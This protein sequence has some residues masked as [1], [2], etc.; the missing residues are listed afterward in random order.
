M[1]LIE[2]SK[3]SN[4]EFITNKLP[5]KKNISNNILENYTKLAKM[6]SS[7]H[8][9]EKYETNKNLMRLNNKFFLNF[10]QIRLTLEN[11][12]NCNSDISSS[13]S[14]EES[15]EKLIDD[16]SLED[17]EFA[18]EKK[19][20]ETP[21]IVF[22]SLAK[23]VL[24][25]SERIESKKFSSHLNLLGGKIL[26]TFPSIHLKTCKKIFE[27]FFSYRKPIEKNNELLVNQKA[28]SKIFNI[29]KPD[30]SLKEMCFIDDYEQEKR[31]STE[32]VTD[33]GKKSL[34]KDFG[35]FSFESQ[36]NE[37]SLE[38]ES[39]SSLKYIEN[40]L[41]QEYISSLL[42]PFY[43]SD[44][45]DDK[46]EHY[47]VNS[48]KIINHLQRYFASMNS[49]S[50]LESKLEKIK[51]S[52]SSSF[53]KESS[54]FGNN[55]SSKIMNPPNKI[56]NFCWEKNEQLE[57]QVGNPSCDKDI[58]VLDLDETLIHC[59]SPC[60]KDKPYDAKI[61][62]DEIGVFVRPGIHE[63]LTKLSVNF[64][65]VLFSAGEKSYIHAILEK[66]NL[67]DYFYIVLS[68][69]DTVKISDQL[70]VKDL[71][72]IKAL[73]VEYFS[74]KN[75]VNEELN[76]LDSENLNQGEIV[77]EEIGN[78]NQIWNNKKIDKQTEETKIKNKAREIILIDNNILSAAK[79]IESIILISNFFE[80]K[81]DLGLNDC[82]DFIE[83]IRL[84]KF[85]YGMNLTD[86]LENHFCFKSLME[87]LKNES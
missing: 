75:K 64:N 28:S 22:S 59:E 71:N 21:K 18:D 87:I 72:L 68:K 46:Y 52:L 63:F 26:N 45:G 32:N 86:Q 34:F 33:N 31:P 7:N 15:I 2:K 5:I 76:V 60:S 37:S 24:D 40:Q 67:R 20:D 41:D 29:R 78:H 79:Q 1:N 47:V 66:L 50:L 85:N 55:Y 14:R 42:V 23:L 4:L 83:E 51:F 12:S 9:S 38:Q 25:E 58:L 69:E 65:L 35:S 84:M 80:D 16:D 17:N 43:F 19:K 57:N 44:L 39:R 81:S 53:S 56:F 8:L 61:E 82:Y 73:D 74:L 30:V 48:L 6:S 27:N 62:G 13:T 49:E 11:F 77:F 54:L 70:F 3:S 10:N 36:I